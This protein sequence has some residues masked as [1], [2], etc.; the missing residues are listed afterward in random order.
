M[1]VSRQ[2]FAIIPYCFTLVMAVL[3]FIF[4]PLAFD[5]VAMMLVF[6]GGGCKFLFY[7]KSYG[8]N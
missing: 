8:R 3:Y 4:F 5:G 7:D 2:S 6:F 1:E